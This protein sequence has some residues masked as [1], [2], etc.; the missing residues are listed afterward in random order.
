MTHDTRALSQDSIRELTEVELDEVGGG[1]LNIN[2]HAKNLG[3]GQQN[4]GI[5]FLNL[6]VG[7]GELKL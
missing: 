3:V 5:S 2:N 4:T 6:N 7:I 1:F